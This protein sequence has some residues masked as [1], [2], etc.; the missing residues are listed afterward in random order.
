[1]NEQFHLFNDDANY[2]IFSM[3][4]YSQYCGTIPTTPI[5]LEVELTKENPMTHTLTNT[6]IKYFVLKLPFPDNKTTDEFHQLIEVCLKNDKDDKT[7]HVL[8]DRVAKGKGLIEMW[9]S[10]IRVNYIGEG[11]G[12]DL[13]SDKWVDAKDG[14]CD[15]GI[16]PCLT[17][18]ASKTNMNYSMNK[19]L[20]ICE[21]F[22]LKFKRFNAWF[23][24]QHFATHAYDMVT[25][26]KLD[27]ENWEIMEI[28]SLYSGL[29][30]KLD[31]IDP[32]EI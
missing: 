15:G 20:R 1:M 17:T 5:H 21:N 18:R 28:H 23:N 6:V 30:P 25:G 13:H 12:C 3:K 8:I 22:L 31:F 4:L 2:T 27:F 10:A 32:V 7:H 29:E 16:T 24:C 14:S 26:A 9:N 11:D 19:M